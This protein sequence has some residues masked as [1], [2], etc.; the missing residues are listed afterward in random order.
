MV[1][2]SSSCVISIHFHLF[3]KV[4]KASHACVSPWESPLCLVHRQDAHEMSGHLKKCRKCQE[5]MVA[6]LQRFVVRWVLHR[7]PW[8]SVWHLWAWHWRV[9]KARA[10]HRLKSMFVTI[11]CLSSFFIWSK[12]SAPR[13]HWIFSHAPKGP[14]CRLCPALLFEG[15]FSRCDL[16]PASMEVSFRSREIPSP[17]PVSL[18]PCQDARKNTWFEPRVAG[19]HWYLPLALAYQRANLWSLKSETFGGLHHG[20]TPKGLN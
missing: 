6:V 7:L 10:W 20:V 17:N 5:N 4:L 11:F 3:N 13:P 8:W 9:G 12:I 18:P 2:W 1:R 16:K 15:L 14:E 19:K